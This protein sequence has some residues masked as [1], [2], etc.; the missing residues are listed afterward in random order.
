[1]LEAAAEAATAAN[2]CRDAALF[3]AHA[4]LRDLDSNPPTNS[5]VFG[6]AMELIEGRDYAILGSDKPRTE[7][8]TRRCRS[9]DMPPAAQQLAQV[10][11]PLPLVVAPRRA[12]K[13]PPI[14]HWAQ[15]G[16][17]ACKPP[18]CERKT[19]AVRTSTRARAFAQPRTC[20]GPVACWSVEISTPSLVTLRPSAYMC[21]RARVYAYD[22]RKQTVFRSFH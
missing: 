7:T 12:E 15:R 6:I 13:I 20:Q 21:A 2:G 17:H 16:P 5:R 11:P 1:M 19:N 9:T 8:L 3:V 4:R 22:D 14:D 10:T 18:A